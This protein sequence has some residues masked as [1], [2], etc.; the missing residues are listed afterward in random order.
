MVSGVASISTPTQKLR[1]TGATLVMFEYSDL[2]QLLFGGDGFYDSFVI[3]RDDFIT[4][5]IDKP[6][7][8]PMARWNFLSKE[9]NEEGD[10]QVTID[11]SKTD[12][13]IAHPCIPEPK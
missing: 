9:D 5:A 2:G 4:N 3:Y 11:L 13:E 12:A 6:N 1:R 7:V 8:L 10:I